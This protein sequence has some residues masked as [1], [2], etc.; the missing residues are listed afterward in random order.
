MYINSRP[1]KIVGSV[2]MGMISIKVDNTVKIG[3]VVEIISENIN[4]QTIAEHIG[5]TTYTVITN[6]S[7]ELPRLYIEG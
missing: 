4:A 6:I 1:Y 2:C 7:Y 3:D 5:K